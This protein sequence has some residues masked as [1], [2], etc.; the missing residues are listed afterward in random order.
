MQANKTE[1]H[2]IQAHPS[3]SAQ[4]NKQNNKR[5]KKPRNKGKID[6]RSSMNNFGVKKHIA[7]TCVSVSL[8]LCTC[9][10]AQGSIFTS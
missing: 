3:G 8:C 10:F 1:K 2:E 6:F 4:T 9:F 5:N 7:S